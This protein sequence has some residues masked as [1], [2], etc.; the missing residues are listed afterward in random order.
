MKS[1]LL[2]ALALAIMTS[3][4]IEQPPAFAQ[5]S[6][7][8]PGAPAA[9]MRTLAQI[10]PRT[11]IT[12]V[13]YTIMLPGSY[14]LATNCSSTT[15]GIIIQASRVTVDLMGFSLTGDRESGDYG[16]WLD[17]ATNA[18]LRDITVRGGMVSGFGEG[19]RCEY[20]QNSRMEGLAV[21]SNL[22]HGIYLNGSRGRCNRNT[23]VHCAVRDNGLNGV[24]LDGSSSGQCN[25]NTTAH[26]V[27][28]GSSGEGVRLY[29]NSGACDGNTVAHCTVSHSVSNG[30]CLNGSSGACN[31]NTVTGCNVGDSLQYGIYLHAESGQCEGNRVADCVLRKNANCGIYLYNSTA[32]RIE[33]NHVSATTGAASYGIYSGSGTNLILRNT[34]VGQTNNYSLNA[35]NTYGPIVTNSGELATSGTAAHPW[36]NFSR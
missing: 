27:I 8:P 20:A 7:T 9:A 12:N 26:C 18:A 35:G 10:E 11:P 32:N 31:G 29:G 16:I 2:K 17:G 4:I 21:S 3:P 34:C 5:G 28:S 33:N 19:V 13:P 15:H 25:G 14:Y 36:A 1:G 23:I 22:N 24:Y 30:I 6:L